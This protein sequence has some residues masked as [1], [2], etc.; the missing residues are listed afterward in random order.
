MIFGEAAMTIA[1]DRSP[2]P[3]VFD[4]GLPSINYEDAQSPDEAH[5]IIR[6]ARM[7]ARSHSD[8]TA[9]SC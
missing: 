2:C 3:S 7:R 6:L 5:E 8:R 1:V 4:A 9:P